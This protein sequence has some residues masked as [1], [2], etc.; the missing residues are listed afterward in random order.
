MI[1][2][3]RNDKRRVAVHYLF[4]IS[5]EISHSFSVW[6]TLSLGNYRLDCL[7]G[8]FYVS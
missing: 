4:I 3:Y 6:A 8:F 1:Q 5:L 7:I 2:D